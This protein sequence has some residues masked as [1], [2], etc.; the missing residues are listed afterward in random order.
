[1]FVSMTEYLQEYDYEFEKLSLKFW[2]TSLILRVILTVA[3]HT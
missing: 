2:H 3:S 1:M